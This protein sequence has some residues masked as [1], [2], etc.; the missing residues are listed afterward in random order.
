MKKIIVALLVFILM[1]PTTF[2]V[3]V[4]ADEKEEPEI[5][6]SG[7]YENAYRYN[8]QG[9]IYLHIEG[10]PYERGY[11]HGYLLAAEIVD[12]INRWSNTIH[13]SP[14]L[15][16]RHFDHE[17]AKY[18]RLSNTWW[19]FCRSRI[20]HIYWD[21]TPEEYQEEIRGIADGVKEQN[22]YVHGREVD[23]IDILAINEMYEF[24]V[25]SENSR[26]DF[27]PLRGLFNGIKSLI[28]TGLGDMESF[29][30]SFLGTPPTHHCNAFI[31]TGNATTEGQI[32][33]A[34]DIRC[35]GWWYSYY[36]AQR[37]NV[38]T[39]ILPSD[40]HRLIMVSSPGY[41]WSDENYY[42]NEQGIVILDTTCSQ[43]LWRNRGYSMAIR[44]RMAAQYSS[45]LDQAIDYLMYKNDGIW[46]AAYLIGDTKTGEIARLDL[47]LYNYEI[48]RTFNGFYWSANNA[49]SKGVRAEANGLGL[50]GILLKMIGLNF[51]AYFT[52][53]YF[54]AP[55][56]A[57][58]EELGEKYYGDIDIEVLKDKIMYEYPIT[59]NSTTDIKATD[60]QLM[61]ANSLWAFW[62]NARG[63][64]WDVSEQELNLKEARN[65][66]PAGWTLIYGLPM[67]HDV[68][69]PLNIKDMKRRPHNSK[70][71]WEYDFAKDFEGRNSWY[72]N[73]AYST[74][75]IFGA[76]LDGAV[77][78]LDAETGE[79]LWV[80]KV[81]DYGG[82]TWI[83]T[84]QEL[85][86]V[87]WENESCAL[88]QITGDVVWANDDINFV[89][90]QPV[91]INNKVI[92]G[93][94]NGNLYA[95]NLA[96]GKIVWHTTLKQ[97]KMY[98]SA[99][100]NS[101]RI[102]VA[103][104]REC[105]ALDA[106]DGTVKWT[107]TA[108][109]MLFSPP[110]I[111]GNTVYFG[112]CDTNIYALEANTGELKWKHSTGWGIV[113]TP[114][115]SDDTVF[116][117][118]LDHHMYALKAGDGELS[119]SFECN[120]AIHSSPV[121]Y[122]EYVFF[123]SDDGWY[124]ALNK[125]NGNIAWSFASNNTID[126][127][128]YNYITTAVVGNSLADDGM[129]FTSTNGKIYGFDA[130]TIEPEVVTEKIEEIPL[131]TM[132]YI[133]IILFVTIA[134]IGAAIYLNKTRKTKK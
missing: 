90:S 39:D 48:W 132:L 120:A 57:K 130:Q 13:N 5:I 89:S 11:Q 30:E 115:F 97:Q 81:N 95:V 6:H 59:D 104:D 78:A 125:S 102:I 26:K 53:R 71:L 14:L 9:W 24:M 16:N 10:E 7:K 105:Y 63:M 27:H 65:V 42:Q 94:R 47:G 74:D 51:Y 79:K 31:A 36:I 52:R 107:F 113:A 12:H 100:K 112:S 3:S 85:V 77:Y 17:S 45:N 44:M 111:V 106:A 29:V 69:L 80:K 84:D 15:E 114:A 126:E 18:E 2:Y 122:G 20:K 108:N 49:I 75:T 117:G 119:W 56:D 83:N 93:S 61:E 40:G 92:F 103:N 22:G 50:K 41:I 62:G 4:L 96:D 19:N 76:G 127:D 82:I 68:K 86:I 98:P 129:I 25:R 99:S 124:Y 33:A 60:T 133:A 118:S 88:D 54:H 21:R 123:G 37:W 72:A 34:H 1:L 23:Y 58:F 91:F 109:E 8:I 110:L 134:I 38:I 28:P 121:V 64:I 87:G 67:G 128:V 70:I 43:G 35:G 73:L 101:N 32:V 131:Q 46:T 66:P 55:R 116:A